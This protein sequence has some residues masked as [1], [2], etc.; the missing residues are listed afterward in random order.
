MYVLYVLAAS[1]VSCS[2]NVYTVSTVQYVHNGSV[3]VPLQMSFLHLWD[4]GGYPW[5]VEGER[6]REELKVHV[7]MCFSVPFVVGSRNLG[8]ADTSF[9]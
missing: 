1:V 8:L 3:L 4:K 9:G 2:F 7:D 6:A 5:E